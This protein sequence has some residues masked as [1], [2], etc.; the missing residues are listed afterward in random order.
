M[1]TILIV[2]DDDSLLEMLRTVVEELDHT[3]L[4]A[5]N[6]KEAWDILNSLAES[7]ALLITDRMMPIMN[8]LELIE[9]VRQS[10]RFARLPIILMSAAG[11]G[12]DQRADCF[13]PK[14]FNLDQL[15]QEIKR[16]LQA[17]TTDSENSANIA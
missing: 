15:E 10:Q 12:S 7:P 14:P 9:L 16:F 11:S 6:G 5:V 4:C 8:G 13:I 1:A 17:R 3:P 2:D